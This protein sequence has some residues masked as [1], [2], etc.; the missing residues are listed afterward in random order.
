MTEAEPLTGLSRYGALAAELRQRIV[1][2]EWLPGSALPAEQRLA[3]E[4]GVALG[5]L[6]QALAVLAD[7][8][9]VERRHG[10]GTFVRAALAGAPM[11]RFFRFGEHDGE[12]PASRI[13]ARQVTAAPVAVA[14]G[15][16]LPSGARVLRLRRLRS[17]GGL[18]RLLEELWL[19]LPLFDA[20]VE[21]D[22]AGWGDLLYPCFAERC[23][24]YVH[25]AVDQ[26]GFGTLNATDARTLKLA[27]GHP[28]ALVQRQAY[29]LAGRCVEWRVT[30]GDAAAFRYTVSI[31]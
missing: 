19:P 14:A 13:V 21:S 23:G 4:R 28:C 10:R 2:G 12:V 3:A 1:G 29:D 20:L 5:T 27:T 15:L 22:T 17:V 24:V 25:R 26:I 18:P 31:T 30:R 6:R 9:L 11:F 7:E 8:G 16:E